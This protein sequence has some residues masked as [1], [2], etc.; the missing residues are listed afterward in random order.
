MLSTRSA[1]P[2][3]T[4]LTAVAATAFWVTP[5]QAAPSA[6]VLTR[7]AT[8]AASYDDSR[9]AGYYLDSNGTLIANVI[10]RAAADE[11][12]A[13]GASTRLV[14]H[15]LRQLNGVVTTLDPGV[16]GT[17][18]S[19]DIA[20][21]QVVVDVD[22][23]VTGSAWATVNAAVVKAAGA[24][25]VQRVAGSFRDLIGGGDAIYGGQFRCSLGFNV[26][27]GSANSFLTAGH[28]TNEAAE[29]FADSG[30]A[31]K[32]GNRTGTSFPGN[33]YG[34]VAYT[35]TS[36]TV[37]GTAGAQDIVSAGDAYVGEPVRR[38]GSTTGTKSGT[39]T[40]LNATVHYVGGD[41]VTGMIRTNVC[42]E[43]GDSG[44]PLYDASIALGLT[45][46]GSGDCRVGGT[47]FYQPVTEALSVY[48]MSVL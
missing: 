42:A 41:T 16:A 21:N 25:R 32:L 37:S 33:D 29:W 15:S 35:N 47:T 9:S 6:E 14:R 2:F 30:H 10:D 44:G 7:V 12:R 13:A 43:P 3:I 28:C 38:T 24:A 11:F 18:W 26:H 1:R 19:V 36:I 31:T 17:A 20:T 22:S 4:V 39:V 5:A 40:G 23:T 45:S 8:L 34:I 27:S 46:G 48:G